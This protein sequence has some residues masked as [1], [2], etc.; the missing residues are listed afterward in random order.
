MRR[1]MLILII[2]LSQRSRTLNLIQL[3]SCASI[4]VIN[5]PSSSTWERVKL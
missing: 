1:S 3:T 2:L 5:R 4:P